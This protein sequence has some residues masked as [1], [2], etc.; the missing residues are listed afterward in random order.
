MKL[1]ITGSPGVGKTSVS[2]M[3]AEK[4]GCKSLNEK[5][6]SLEKRIGEFDV[7]ENE[8]VVDVKKLEQELKKFLKK[9]KNI[10]LE[11]HLLCETKIPIDFAILIRTDPEM[12]ESRLESRGYT[13]EK[14]QDNV[15]CE[16]IDYCKKHIERRYPKKEIIEVTSK[17]T[18]K[19]TTEHILKEIEQRGKIK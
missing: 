10:V 14:I 8:L 2:K 15:F 9:E 7:D 16:G 1:L 5:E 17:K 12:L 18:I 13:A 6:F 19:E 3:L 4:L 11:G